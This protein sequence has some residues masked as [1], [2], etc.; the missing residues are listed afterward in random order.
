MFTPPTSISSSHL[1]CF[2]PQNVPDLQLADIT[3]VPWLRPWV[4]L[5][6]HF[7]TDKPDCI[8]HQDRHFALLFAI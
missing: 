1:D 7:H 8:A 2:V 6:A 5:P 4:N 3:Q